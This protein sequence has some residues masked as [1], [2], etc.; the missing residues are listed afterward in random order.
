MEEWAEGEGAF[1]GRK[2]ALE[3]RQQGAQLSV[4]PLDGCVMV[5]KLLSSLSLSFLIFKKWI[6]I[7]MY[8]LLHF[9]EFGVKIK[10]FYYSQ[11]TEVIC[12]S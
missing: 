2:A 8:P 3:I 1:H 11:H 9:T 6:M 12:K 7:S 4:L 5:S 10:A